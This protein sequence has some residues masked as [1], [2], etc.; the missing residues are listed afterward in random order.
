MDSFKTRSGL[1]VALS[2]R[3]FWKIIIFAK[4]GEPILTSETYYSKSNA[5]RALL[6]LKRVLK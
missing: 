6:N 2:K 5:G 4:N 3:L 1:E